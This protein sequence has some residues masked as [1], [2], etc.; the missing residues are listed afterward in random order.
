MASSA[1]NVAINGSVI[2]E[3][4][5]SAA[6][7]GNQAYQRIS[8]A[9]ASGKQAAWHQ[10]QQHQRNGGGSI[11]RKITRRWRNGSGVS[12]RIGGIMA[13]AW[14]RMKSSSKRNNDVSSSGS[15]IKR[16]H[17][18]SVISAYHSGGVARGM[19]ALSYL[20]NSNVSL[21]VLSVA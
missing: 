14:R 9:A 18:R 19:A 12:W 21:N 15:S 5:S 2:T 17:Q 20:S 16:W 6:T 8:G 13:S 7:G 3:N 11:A 4:I 10:R 1:N